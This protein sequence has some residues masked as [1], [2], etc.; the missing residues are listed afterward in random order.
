M[1]LGLAEKT[2]I[3]SE[4]SDRTGCGAR[5]AALCVSALTGTQWTRLCPNTTRAERDCEAIPA[6]AF[7]DDELTLSKPRFCRIHTKAA[8]LDL[9]QS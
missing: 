9:Q 4:R 7:L 8:D 5:P 1:Q 6:K 3:V 2:G